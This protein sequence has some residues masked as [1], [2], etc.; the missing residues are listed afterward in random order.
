[1]KKI[2]ALLAASACVW[3]TFFGLSAVA[4]AQTSADKQVGTK[5]I[6]GSVIFHNSYGETVCTIPVPDTKGVYSFHLD[7][8]VCENNLVASF[9]LE[10]IPSATL[11]QFYGNETCSDGRGSENFF[12]KLKTVKQPTDWV[13][14]GDKMNFNDLRNKAPGELIPKR[15]IRVDDYWEGNEIRG[16]EWAE[17]ISCVYI[18]R[19][20]PIN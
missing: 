4:M 3:V 12:I 10:I 17:K 5:A 14:I 18:E 7:N 16:E 1:M 6:Y 20:Q 9:T 19:S 11:I 8:S 15:N 13:S 2:R